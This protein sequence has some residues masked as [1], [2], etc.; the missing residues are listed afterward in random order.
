MEC[1]LYDKHQVIDNTC[2]L[3]TNLKPLKCTKAALA[4]VYITPRFYRK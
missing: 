4:G 3:V 1:G 2:L